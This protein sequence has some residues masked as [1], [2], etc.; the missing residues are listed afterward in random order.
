MMLYSG[1]WLGKRCQKHSLWC[2]NPISPWSFGSPSSVIDKSP[3]CYRELTAEYVKI[4]KD[5]CD[6]NSTVLAGHVGE[7]CLLPARDHMGPFDLNQWEAGRRW[8]ITLLSRAW[9]VVHDLPCL[10]FHGQK[11]VWRGTLFQPAPWGNSNSPYHSS[12][13]SIRQAEWVRNTC[14]TRCWAGETALLLFWL[15]RSLK[16]TLPAWIPFNSSAK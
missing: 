5:H 16:L 10:I 13:P 6:G 11:H 4:W 12:C 14:L 1:I 2:L 15:I 9:V 3:F 7:R 8:C